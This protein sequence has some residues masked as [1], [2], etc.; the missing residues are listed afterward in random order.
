M[1]GQGVLTRELASSVEID[2][3]PG[4]VWDVLTDFASYPEWN[5]FIQQI[6]GETQI[7]A[8]L[9]VRIA[10]PGGRPMTF[11]PEVK[12]A[13]RDRELRWLGRFLLPGLVDGE[14]T[15][16][17]EPLPDGRSRFRQEERF[18]GLLVPLTTRT[19]ERTQAGF[20]RMNDA[21]KARAE[22]PEPA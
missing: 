4:R 9:E 18:S 17:I 7:G 13:E 1:T 10:P 20:E 14:H 5:P 8:R 21:L 16:R 2:A 11:K 22:R 3:P 15:L 12:A 19:L 6:S